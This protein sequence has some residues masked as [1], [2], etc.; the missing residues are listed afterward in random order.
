MPDAP[1][2]CGK[3]TRHTATIGCCPL[4]HELFSSE[5]AFRKHRRPGPTCTPPSEVGLVARP[6]KTAEGEVI[7]GNPSPENPW[8]DRN[9]ANEPHG[10]A[11]DGL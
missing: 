7:W 9:K 8:W 6:S 4:C 5:T 1:F 2:P 11:V 3:R 10:D